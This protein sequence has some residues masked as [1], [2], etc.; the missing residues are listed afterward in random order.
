LLCRFGATHAS[1]ALQDQLDSLLAARRLETV[2]I[3]K[4]GLLCAGVQR[5][6]CS[7]EGFDVNDLLCRFPAPEKEVHENEESLDY[8]G[9]IF[10][11]CWMGVDPKQCLGRNKAVKKA[12]VLSVIK[13]Q[14]HGTPSEVC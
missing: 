7:L 13:D 9:M 14:V 4:D 2:V 10:Q 3:H 8:A 12:T 6:K 11:T 5:T 1:K